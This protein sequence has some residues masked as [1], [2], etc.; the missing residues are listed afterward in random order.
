MPTT[1]E[2]NR[3]SR[4]SD[5]VATAEDGVLNPQMTGGESPIS[6]FVETQAPSATM[7]TTVYLETGMIILKPHMVL[8]EGDLVPIG[9]GAIQLVVPK[10]EEWQRDLEEE[11]EALCKLEDDFDGEGSLSIKAANIQAAKTFVHQM[12]TQHQTR[13]SGAYPTS[14]GGVEV[15]IETRYWEAAVTIDNPERVSYLVKRGTVK[16]SGTA[17]LIDVPAKIWEAFE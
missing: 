9:G 13:C 2:L 14:G 12:H 10:K 6:E 5:A 4:P 7:D 8:G 16:T 15:E 11:I 17:P 1:S 3:F